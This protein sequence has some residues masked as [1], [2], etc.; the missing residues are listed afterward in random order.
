VTLSARLSTL[1]RKGGAIV[2]VVLK[3]LGGIAAL[4]AIFAC[5]VVLFTFT[6]LSSTPVGQS[7]HEMLGFGTNAAT[8]AALDASGLKSK[9][10]DTL[11]A[12]AGDIA[13]QTGMSEEQVNQAIDKLDIES[14][15]VTSLPSDVKETGSQKVNYGGVSAE[16]ITYDNPSYL[17]VSAEGQTFTLAVPDSAQEYVPLLGYLG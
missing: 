11:Y 9:A 7:V 14:W 13:A 5:V 12:N 4:L 6:P 1:N 15:S 16:V 3:L 10:E 17:T 8:N 2:N